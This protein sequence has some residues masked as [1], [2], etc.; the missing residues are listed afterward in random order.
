MGCNLEEARENCQKVNGRDKTMQALFE[1]DLN[2]V[3]ALMRDSHDSPKPESGFGLGPRPEEFCFEVTRLVAKILSLLQTATEAL[4][5]TILSSL[6]A[7]KNID[8][9]LCQSG[10][11]LP[12]GQ[13]SGGQCKAPIQ[14]GY[15]SL[16]NK[17]FA[18]SRHS[19]TG[20]HQNCTSWLFSPP[21]F[22][23]TFKWKRKAWNSFLLQQHS[24]TELYKLCAIDWLSH[25]TTADTQ[26]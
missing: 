25:G 26:R 2:Q 16:C 6:S 23:L 4:C 13:R 14:V 5:Q 18:Q 21:P 24:L 19:Y 20:K 15:Q 9:S 7:W 11:W 12:C 3:K 22:F 1:D 10:L 8:S 17:T